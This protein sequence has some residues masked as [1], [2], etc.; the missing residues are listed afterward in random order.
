MI[1]VTVERG[2]TRVLFEGEVAKV[3]T[4]VRNFLSNVQKEE[5]TLAIRAKE[6]ATDVAS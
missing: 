6:G 4:A 1:K 2:A 5:W 3:M